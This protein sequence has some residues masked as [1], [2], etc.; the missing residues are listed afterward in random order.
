[1]PRVKR[2][3]ERQSSGAHKSKQKRTASQPS[4]PRQAAPSWSLLPT[5][6]AQHTDATTLVAA[7]S[8]ASQHPPAELSLALPP[9]QKQ[10]PRPD[11]ELL[12]SPSGLLGRAGRPHRKVS[13][14]HIARFIAA[15]QRAQLPAAQQT[16]LYIQEQQQQQQQ[17]QY[18]RHEQQLQ[19]QML[20]QQE[21]HMLQ[22]MALMQQRHRQRHHLQ[23]RQLLQQQ[24]THTAARRRTGSMPPGLPLATDLSLLAQVKDDHNAPQTQSTPVTLATATGYDSRASMQHSAAGAPRAGATVALR[25]LPHAVSSSV[26]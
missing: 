6:A 26:S 4:R 20:Q 24:Q 3:A 21:R 15:Q 25:G 12:P 16:H 18:H 19:M 9:G 8:T 7:M 11:D 13:H 14:I 5:S 10:E 17:Q 22:Q 1:M 2:T 23:Q